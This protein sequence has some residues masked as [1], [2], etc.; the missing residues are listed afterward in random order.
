MKKKCYEKMMGESRVGG[1]P[2]VGWSF[3]YTFGLDL[4]KKV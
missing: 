2:S 4:G 3:F 1:V